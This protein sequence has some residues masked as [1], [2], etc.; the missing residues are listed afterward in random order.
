MRGSW[1]GLLLLCCLPSL[2]LAAPLE[3]T[4]KEKGSGVLIEGA[5]VVLDEGEL[6]GQTSANGRLHFDA[7]GKQI[8]V[9]AT[10]YESLTQGLKAEQGKLT[11]YLR[12][13]L[14]ESEGLQV[15][16]ERLLE[17]GSKLTL[18]TSELLETAGSGGDPLK[19]I[20]ALPGIIAASEGS[21]EVY[22]RGS[23][24]NDNITWVN[25]A[26]V[27]YL[28][29]F[30]GIKSTI[31]PAL[32]KDINVFLGGFP[33]QYGD[34]LGGVVDARLRDPKTDRLH[35]DLDISS[36]DSSFLV[37]GPVGK[38]GDS[39]F[40]AGRRS[41]LD[42]LLSPSTAS[43]LFAKPDDNDPDQVLLVPRFYDLQ[44]LYRKPL[45]NGSLES[46]LFAAE[47]QIAIELRSSA[48]SDPQLAGELHSK[49]AYQ[50]VGLNWQQRWGG[51][52]ESLT[53]LAYS[54]NKSTVRLGRDENGE[55]FYADV[56]QKSLHLQPEWRRRLSESASITLGADLNA[57][58]IPLDL[59][60][61]RR[62]TENDI[63]VDFTSQQK[64]RVKTELKAQG[65]SPYLKYRQRWGNKLTTQLGLRSSNV[66]VSGGFEA[67]QF[68]PRLGLEYQLSDKTLLTANWGR[69]LQMPEGDQIVSGFGN[70][71]LLMREAEHRILGIE[72]Q[73]G[74]LYTV[75]AEIY[76]KP[77]K[78]LVV[79]LDGNPP[80]NN[81]ANRGSGEAVG[82][83]LFLKRKP[84]QGKRGWLSMSWAKSERTNEIT[85]IT[86]DFS[87]D[88]PLTLVAVWGQPFSGSWN[89][90]DWSVKAEVHSGRPYTAVIG[91]HQEDPTNINSRWLPEFGKHNGERLPVYRKVDLRLSR[92]FLFNESKMQFYLDLQN[93]TFANNVVEYD[94]G[95]EY[96]KIDKPTEISGL[97]FF[98]YLGL[99]MEF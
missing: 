57:V 61:P 5:T 55:S 1:S 27:G 63:Q 2:L 30:G 14:L 20:T 50:T 48:T 71:A 3:V 34:A 28:Y 89:R 10:G 54:H 22:M 59:Y 65:L 32:I 9:L 68:S 43:D 49:S 83:D 85:G 17:K 99:K 67:Q 62:Q 47:D 70:P 98:P 51:A 79:A 66:R 81:L 77:M 58:T 64:F 8:K 11:L 97:S 21:A 12:P 46:Y 87:G 36:I 75:K 26:P 24:G 69:Y 33:V 90:W 84:S 45:A 96:E 38:T 53:N 73:L 39:F 13:L 74:A 15:S 6:Y 35:I 44:G 31:N 7:S 72:Q 40:V 91:R 25:H 93:V 56:E 92:E 60:V 76:Q 86:R 95:S 52:W 41:Y 16:A 18:S 82:F 94:Y 42:L 80:P 78:N 37:E 23:N 88:Q 19:A 29:H 4:V